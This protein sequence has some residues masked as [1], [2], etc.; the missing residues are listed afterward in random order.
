MLWN[1]LREQIHHL[2]NQIPN[3]FK[4]FHYCMTLRSCSPLNQSTLVIFFF[5]FFFEWLQAAFHQVAFHRGLKHKQC[6]SAHVALSKYG[7][8]AMGGS[9]EAS[10][11]TDRFSR[12][13]ITVS[14]ASVSL[15]LLNP[16]SV[17]AD[18][19]CEQKAIELNISPPTKSPR[20]KTVTPTFPRA[21]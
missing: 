2:A 10:A 20:T 11:R 4:R 12:N 1:I 18:R 8:G 17:S 21:P 15:I 6:R 3:W 19:S 5:F 7:C 16:R 13:S 9:G 14:I